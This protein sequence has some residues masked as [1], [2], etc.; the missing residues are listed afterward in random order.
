MRKRTAWLTLLGKLALG[1][2]LLGFLITRTDVQSLVQR[3]YRLDLFYVA[4]VFVIP[5]VA[6]WLSSVKWQMLLRALGIAVPIKRLFALYMIGQFFNNFFP[7]M[8]G[9]DAVKAYQLSRETGEAPPVIAATFME[10]FIGLAAL[11][12]LSPLV[13]LQPRVYDRFPAVGFLVCFVILGYLASLVLIFSNMGA[14]LPGSHSRFA[15]ARRLAVATQETR[16]RVRF[17]RHRGALLSLSYFISLLF[18]FLT[19]AGSWAATRSTG[20]EVEYT[21][22]L[23]VV[24]IILLAALLPVSMNGLGITETG[25]VLFLGL[26]GVPTVEAVTM[27]LLVRFRV[28]VTAAVG[29]LIFILY[30]PSTSLSTI[31]TR[32]SDLHHTGLDNSSQRRTDTPIDV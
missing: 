2:A 18:Y 22:L 1:L 9:G 6:M 25:Y 10:R 29:G 16:T 31:P 13:L 21:Y 3:V 4:I 28:L 30:K 24:P 20:A 8:V 11:V 26:A 23:A 17:F 32:S 5:H 12:S 27:A 14:H 7:T 15:V 19:A